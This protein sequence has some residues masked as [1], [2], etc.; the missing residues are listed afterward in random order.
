MAMPNRF[1]SVTCFDHFDFIFGHGRGTAWDVG[2]SLHQTEI[3]WTVGSQEP[4]SGFRAIRRDNFQCEG[5]AGVIC[6]SRGPGKEADPDTDKGSRS[7]ETNP[8]GQH[9]RGE[10]WLLPSD[11]CQRPFIPLF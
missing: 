8:C 10:T 6:F 3:E 4:G 7:K 1:K 5:D 2:K 11:S 9:L